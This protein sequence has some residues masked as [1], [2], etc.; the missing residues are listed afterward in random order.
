MLQIEKRLLGLGL[1][2]CLAS[3]ALAQIPTRAPSTPNA[4]PIPSNQ[5][6]NGPYGGFNAMRPAAPAT[7][8][9]PSSSAQL[10]R[11]FN[12]LTVPGSQGPLAF[13]PL[14][15]TTVPAPGTSAVQPPAA[16]PAGTG[17]YGGFS[18]TSP[19][20]PGGNQ[21]ATAPPTGTTATG[22]PSGPYGGFNA[23]RPGTPSS[24]TGAALP[25]PPAP[26]PP[27]NATSPFDRLFNGLNA[28]VPV[29][30]VPSQLGPTGAA[31]PGASAAPNG[32]V[33]TVPGGA[34][35]PSPGTTSPAAPIPT[36]GSVPR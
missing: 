8:P 35:T 31:F 3:P 36:T 24:A 22:T 9:P 29:N 21:P 14:P 26:L 28:A 10:F 7:N 16:N 34:V 13:S 6:A 1:A 25:A 2:F 20:M 12:G 19:G 15:G 17:P 30:P 27:L 11:L 4:Q 5:P 33:G 18:A 23:V 32:G